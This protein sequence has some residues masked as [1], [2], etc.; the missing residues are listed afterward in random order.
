MRKLLAALF[1]FGSVALS[2]EAPVV[3][4]ADDSV[5]VKPGDAPQDKNLVWDAASKT[6]TLGSA[7][8]EYVA[9]QIVVKSSND[10][11]AGVTVTPEAL[12]G[13][14][15]AEI[16][17]G[18]IELFVEHYLNVTISSRAGGAQKDWFPGCTTGEHPT[19]MVPFNADRFGAPFPVWA[20]RNQPVWVDIY[21]PEN[22]AAGSY[23]GTFKV[24]A[25]DVA[26]G[27]VK[28][29]LTVWD[30]TLPIETH[31]RSYL[32]TGPENLKWAHRINDIDSKPFLILEDKYFQ[33]AHQH[34]LNFHPS[35]GDVA[36]EV[37][38]R[39]AKYYDGSG[40]TERVGKG[41][42]QNVINMPPEG[43]KEDAFKASAKR[44]L[45]VYQSKKFTGLMFGYIWD[46]PHSDQDFAESKK[47]C[48]WAHEAA[49][50]VF[51]TFIATPQW[52]K[53]DGG[54]VNIFSETSVEDIPKVLARGDTVWAVNAGY[55]AG[56]YVDAP[57]FGGR[58]IVWMNWKMNLG[59]WQFWDVCYWVDRQNRKHKEG[60]RWVPDMSF[61]DI[62]EDPRLYITDLWRDPLNFDEARKKGY[63]VNDS[64]RING[65]GLLF[66]P[67]E[68]IGIHGPVAS[69]AMK[70]LRR[71]AQDYEYLWLA[72]Q[73]GKEAE[74][75]PIVDSVCPA[76]G[77]WNDDP[78]SWG[79]A[80][81]K[82]AELLAK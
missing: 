20:A 41:A 51:N 55:G 53:Y 13:Q 58:S 30:F 72:K 28:V 42:G 21:V 10:D 23:T 43:D 6:V 60:K 45:D 40:F 38:Q 52:Q 22:A 66:Y 82:L 54:D 29:A 8:N 68:D 3:W 17:L 35:A 36:K 79:K 46:E 62:N 74:I 24:K 18:N 44:N 27:D 16:P 49:G 31:F 7:K 70:S 69:F 64:I 71:G 32:Y 65:D 39:Y 1:L 37:G 12:K 76:A 11:L 67:G 9:F 63:P 50:K 5:K 19:Q 57:G 75:A 34:R 25:G 26:L 56:P 33:M 77:K 61:K 4:C 80:R 81:L 59:G 78:E 48:K 2:G 73:K 14:G 47:R 15:N